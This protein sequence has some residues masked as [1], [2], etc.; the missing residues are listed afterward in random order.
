MQPSER[1]HR[2]LEES[3]LVS[4]M[5]P[6]LAYEEGGAAWHLPIEGLPGLDAEFDEAAHRF[7]LSGKVGEIPESARHSLHEMMLHYN[8]MWSETGGVRIALDGSTN[9]AVV[10]L[11]IAIAELDASRMS[12]LLIDLVNI[13]QAWIEILRACSFNPAED[14]AVCAKA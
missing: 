7:V 14:V 2:L 13:Q 5:E 6:A 8:F 11:E 4:S 3:L 10:M 1:A 12:A 9:Q